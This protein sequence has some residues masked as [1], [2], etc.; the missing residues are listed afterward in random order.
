[1]HVLDSD[2]DGTI[3][4]FFFF[5]TQAHLVLFLKSAGIESEV[6]VDQVLPI[7]TLQ[8]LLLWWDFQSHHLR[9][10]Q[11]RIPSSTTAVTHLGLFRTL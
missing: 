10:K 2:S 7:F 6:S 4:F 5:C 3:C 9:G 11:F 1:M 8:A